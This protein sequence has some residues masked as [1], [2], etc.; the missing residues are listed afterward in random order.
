M[1][2]EDDIDKNVGDYLDFI[3]HISKGDKQKTNGE[4]ENSYLHD[5]SLL[6]SPILTD[7]MNRSNLSSSTDKCD[8]NASKKIQFSNQKHLENDTS[9]NDASSNVSRGEDVIASSVI[10]ENLLSVWQL[11]ASTC[12]SLGLGSSTSADSSQNISDSHNSTRDILTS[13][14]ENSELSKNH[15]HITKKCSENMKKFNNDHGHRNDKLVRI[16]HSVESKNC[17]TDGDNDSALY[18]NNKSSRS[19]SAEFSKRWCSKLSGVTTHARPEKGKDRDFSEEDNER[20]QASSHETEHDAT[21]KRPQ[22]NAENEKVDQA[23]NR[24]DLLSKE[25]KGFD[26][27]STPSTIDSSTTAE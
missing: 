17:A 22:H 16:N 7:Y 8:P 15:R 14:Y 10:K 27:W 12:P 1:N 21:I 11:D 20:G 5:E 3:S 19:R 18:K 9:G 13:D 4:E 6:F 24:D 2:G 26:S 23:V 25:L